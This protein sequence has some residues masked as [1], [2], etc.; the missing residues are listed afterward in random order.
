MSDFLNFEITSFIS[1]II[2]LHRF[3]SILKV[4]Q[5]SCWFSWVSETLV[6]SKIIVPYEK[7]SNCNLKYFTKSIS[8]TTNN[9]IKSFRTGQTMR[10]V[11]N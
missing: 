9:G 7:K 3:I 8:L 4:E 1:Y 2:I 6:F 11:I 5:K 10:I